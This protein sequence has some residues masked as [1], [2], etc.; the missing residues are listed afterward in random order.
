MCACD[1]DIPE[2]IRGTFQFVL[3]NDFF[4]SLQ[5]C[6][7]TWRPTFWCCGS[8]EWH[9]TYQRGG[10]SSERLISAP[11]CQ[12]GPSHH[13]LGPVLQDW[14]C[15]TLASP[16]APGLTCGPR[17]PISHETWQGEWQLLLPLPCHHIFGPRQAG[18]KG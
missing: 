18:L 4:L 16:C 12:I 9:G 1:S 5:T 15:N 2:S 6:Y 11:C 17:L 14:P 8:D 13:L 7:D 3:G 10:S